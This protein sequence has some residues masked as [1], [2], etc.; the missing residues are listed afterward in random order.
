MPDGVGVRN[1]LYSS[2][3]QDLVD[4]G[5]SIIIM[6][7]FDKGFQEIIYQKYPKGKFVFLPFLWVK[8]PFF[9]R[10]KR[11]AIC[12][13]RLKYY[14]KMRN[15]PTLLFNW[16]KFGKQPL[17]KVFFYRFAELY[18]NLFFNNYEAIAKADDSLFKNYSKHNACVQV[19]N[20]IKELQPDVIFLTHQ[21]VFNASIFIEAGKKFNIPTISAIYSWDNMPKARLG[22]RSDYYIAWSEYMKEEFKVY[23]PEIE[24]DR[25]VVLG[26]PQFEFYK[27]ISKIISKEKFYRLQ[28][29]DQNRK[30]ICFSG[31]DQL[32]SPHDPLYLEALILAIR[33]CNL[34]NAVQVLVRPAPA[35]LSNRFDSIIAQNSDIAVLS[36]P[37]IQLEMG[38]NW[39]F[40]IPR[41]DDVKLL[42]STV[43]YAEAVVNVG[44]T[45]ALDF[46]NYNKPAAY[47]N[48]DIKEDPNWSV[49]TIYQFEHFKS[50]KGLDAVYWVNNI[51]D[52]DDFIQRV[53]QDNFDDV[54]KDRKKWLS[55][56]NEFDDHQVQGSTFNSFF[57][58]L[59]NN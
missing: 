30:V 12:Y 17:K 52:L 7:S 25:V 46:A 6:H 29:L 16:K 45:M 38:K 4:Q 48:F 34:V 37:N 42:V 1:Y 9:H 56:I 55:V 24:Q 50:M 21:R 40:A 8:E 54:A 35:D 47:L 27:D 59:I 14:S 44:S 23:H 20:Q 43:F 49:N 36:K 58:Q 22:V 41:P 31:D 26:S 19:E 2:V 5:V 51:N 18:A 10:L 13:A 33:R 32:T 28:H 39:G 11:E 57:S 3:F 15:N 53:A